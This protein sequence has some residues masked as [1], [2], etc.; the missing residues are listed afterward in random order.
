MRKVVLKKTCCDVKLDLVTSRPAKIVNKRTCLGRVD[1]RSC[2][3]RRKVT[4]RRA[5]IVIMRTCRGRGRV[6][7]QSCLEK[8]AS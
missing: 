6:D 3:I 1:A 8:D 2:Q 7:A 5:K 4:S